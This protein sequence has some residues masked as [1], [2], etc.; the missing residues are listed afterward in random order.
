MATMAKKG[1]KPAG[2]GPKE[3]DPAGGKR[4]PSREKLRYVAL[5][6]DLHAA[7]VEYAA[8]HSDEDDDKSISWAA[9]VL[10]KKALTA[11]DRWPRKP[12]KS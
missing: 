1:G 4:P 11:E 5:P 2:E 3:S 6:L 12:K 9:R 8:D 10:L 7:L